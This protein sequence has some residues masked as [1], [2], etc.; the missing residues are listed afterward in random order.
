[1]LRPGASPVA[2]ALLNRW[3]Q[4]AIVTMASGLPA[5]ALVVVSGQQFTGTNMLYTTTLNGSD[6]WR[7][8]PF[9]PINNLRMEAEYNLDV[10]LARSFPI[11]ESMSANLGVEVFNL[12][13]RQT[14][15]SVN[16]TAFLA[17]GGVL[18]P[19]SGLG[20]GNTASPPRSAQLAFRFIF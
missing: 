4:S 10:R 14:V 1:M 9:Q 6:S 7:R 18:T 12:F 20:A 11:G 19:V 2:K 16:T 17:S 13:N 15:T 8:V 5:T 3:Q